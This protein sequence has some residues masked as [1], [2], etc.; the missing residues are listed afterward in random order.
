MTQATDT[1]AQRILE[2]LQNAGEAGVPI[3]KLIAPR[4]D[5]LG[6]AQYNARILELRRA[7]HDIRNVAYKVDGETHT[8]FV[9]QSKMS[10]RLFDA[11]GNSRRY[12]NGY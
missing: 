2:A 3:Y 12:T 5:G 6:V 1:Q 9:L 8:K 11:P 10:G 7:G 4:P